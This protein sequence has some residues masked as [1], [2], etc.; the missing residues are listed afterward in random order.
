MNVLCGSVSVPGSS[1]P[2]EDRILVDNKR[3][4]Y[5][6][7]DGVTISSQGSGGL[8]AEIA[9]S[10][11]K[12]VFRGDLMEAVMEVNKYILDQKYKD[13]RIGETTLTA[14]Y[15][16]EKKCELVNVGD[17]PAIL[18]RDKRVEFLSQED[19]SP[20][21]YL[22]QVLGYSEDIT[23]HRNLFDLSH[24][25]KIIIASDG[26]SHVLTP[27]LILKSVKE[28]PSEFA[29][30]I[31]KLANYYPSSYDDDKSVIVIIVRP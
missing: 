10:R 15:I 31:V 2:Y 1:H 22:L 26:V 9:V 8:A 16:G 4:L 6:V 5:A 23:P 14:C 18:I 29:S 28:D 12:E 24:D 17:S 25:D 21:G 19:R 11:L 20:H 13:R 30:N 7:A 27:E 3:H